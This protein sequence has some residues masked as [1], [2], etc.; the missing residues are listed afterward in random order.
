M[1]LSNIFDK[2]TQLNSI[3]YKRLYSHIYSSSSSGCF[4]KSSHFQLLLPTSL[5]QLAVLAPRID[6]LEAVRL[7]PEQTETCVDDCHVNCKA[8]LREAPH[9]HRDAVVARLRPANSHSENRIINRVERELQRDVSRCDE[10]SRRLHLMVNS[11]NHR[12]KRSDVEH[13]RQLE[14]QR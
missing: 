14:R 1:L 11:R 10:W 13:H 7:R 3:Q 6:V 2:K 5:F 12:V 8:F 4:R 9:C